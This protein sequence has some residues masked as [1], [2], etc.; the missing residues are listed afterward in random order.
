MALNTS[1]VLTVTDV[2]LVTE[3][4]GRE[5]EVLRGRLGRAGGGGLPCWNSYQ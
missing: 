1:V 2:L 3:R 5:E 4:A